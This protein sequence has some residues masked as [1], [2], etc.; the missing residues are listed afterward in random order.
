[1]KIT[2]LNP[3]GGIGAN[4]LLLE[5]GVFRILVDCGLHPKRTGASALPALKQLG[6]AD[7]DLVVLTHC[8]LDHLGSLPIVLR[9]QPHP[10]VLMSIP[11]LHLAE[12]MLH[13]SVN[14]M[15]RER[16]EKG[17]KDYPLFTHGEV[18]QCATRFFGQ[19]YGQPRTL[20]K[21]GEKITLTLHPAGHV[22]GAAGLLIE[23]RKQRIF[24]TGDVLF[25]RQ[26]TL[27]GARFPAVDTEI[28]V[29]ET[30]RGA[31]QREAG[32]DRE[33]ELERL[34]ETI[35]HTYQAGGSILVPVFA[36]GRMQEIFAVLAR[37]RRE[38]RLVKCPV[39]ATGLGM[40]LVDR[41]DEIHRK[42][43]LIQF[44]RS[45]TKILKVEKPAKEILPGRPPRQ[46]LYI[47]SSGMLVEH[48][49]SYKMAAALLGE[50]KHAICFV[51]YCDPDTPG[52]RL[53][54]SNAG[55][56]FLFDKLDYN[57]PVRARV[58]KFELSGHADR[59]ELVDFALARKPRSILLTHGDPPA[60][61]WFKETFAARAPEIEVIDPEPLKSYK[62]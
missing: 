40:D 47:L 1:M 20:H 28:L 13:N 2:D 62:L 58:E 29:M 59:D 49:P 10:A 48:T 45:A 50:H 61:A 17:I 16:E 38:G 53:L 5:I 46:G 6:T 37:A 25:Q 26:E 60:R 19:M 32:R 39:F 7:L 42:T 57:C 18:E 35:N 41:F 12:R 31:T 34:I 22:A 44:S 51:G 55:D 54:A 11:S 9:H 24:L 33:T 30:T 36:L 43:Q 4:S 14:V 8:H 56:S 3:E 52:G 27:A 21:D 15:L 23:Y